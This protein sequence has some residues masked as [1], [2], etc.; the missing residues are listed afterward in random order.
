MNNEDKLL[1][2]KNWA[3]I[4]VSNN[5]DKISYKIWKILLRN[6]YNVYPVN[7]NYD[8]I[9]GEKIYHSLL[10][11]DDDI[12]VVNFVVNPNL[13]KKYLEEVDKKDIKYVWF[14]EESFNEDVVEI[15]NDFN[16]MGVAGRCVYATL[17]LKEKMKK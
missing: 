13:T 12:D 2:L 8:E 16:L 7:K 10:E 15:S 6:G 5:P 17:D 9:E 1:S 4:G 3:V 11:I 14:Q